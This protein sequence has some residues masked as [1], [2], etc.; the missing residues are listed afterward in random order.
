M[1]T[2]Y[3]NY[4]LQ[5][6]PDSVVLYGWLQEEEGNISQAIEVYRRVI[7][8]RQQITNSVFMKGIFGP[9]IHT[10][11]E[12]R[13]AT[14]FAEGNIN[15]LNDAEV[16]LKTIKE[17]LQLD[18]IA[19]KDTYEELDWDICNPPGNRFPIPNYVVQVHIPATNLVLL[20]TAAAI[21]LYE[22]QQGSIP[23]RIQELIPKYLSQSPID[24]FGGNPIK[25]ISSDFG[26]NVY[27]YGPDTTDD[28]G[29]I[30]YDPTNGT[31]SGGDLI[32]SVKK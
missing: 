17:L 20:E 24:T 2:F 5:Q 23:S 7:R 25:F 15:N 14:L 32:I 16:A 31:I 30:I 3:A 8:Y 27:S 22:L 28:K 21:K 9:V 11:G 12:D 6:L 10:T 13:F 29:L 26:I 18:P 4:Q 1:T 19:F